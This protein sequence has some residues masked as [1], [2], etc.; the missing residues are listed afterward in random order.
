MAAECGGGKKSRVKMFGFGIPEQGFYAVE[1]PG[2]KPD[3]ENSLGLVT[4]LEG[5]ASVSK[6]DKE[7]KNLI[8]EEWDFKV[9]QLANGEYMA[10]FPDAISVDMFSKFSSVDLALFGLKARISKSK[11]EATATAILQSTW[12]KVYG[13]PSFAREEEIVK[14]L[15]SLA[16]EPIKVDVASLNKEGPVR[17][18]V[19]CRDPRKLRG[20]VEVFFNGV[21]YELRFVAEG[22][23][24]KNQGGNKGVPPDDKKDNRDNDRKDGSGEDSSRDRHNYKHSVRRE[25][26][27]EKGFETSQGDSMD[28]EMEELVRDDSPG[29]DEENEY[30][31]TETHPHEIGSGMGGSLPDETHLNMSPTDPL[32]SPLKVSQQVQ[33]TELAEVD[34]QTSIVT[35]Q[36]DSQSAAALEIPPGMI[37]VHSL[38]GDYL[39]EE[40]KWPSL[41]EPNEKEDVPN[42][43]ALVEGP[44]RGTTVSF[45]K[46]EEGQAW[47]SSAPKRKGKKIKQPVV[48]SRT[49]ARIPRTGDPIIE[50]AAK[51][52]QEKDDLLQGNKKHQPF[53]HP[54]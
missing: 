38:E 35:S 20:F 10:S 5:N 46:G 49:S 29:K 9:K 30:R 42:Q 7:L 8:D 33:G 47:Q 45:D 19:N 52:M 32:P 36:E 53:Y 12:I 15:T 24:G 14:D 2:V 31:P 50:K 41:I 25:K 43:D 1:I 21:G 18:K 28:E 16:A 11:L 23:H 17:V 48:A 39:V 44:S 26:S 3:A 54:Q 51:R 34:N 4:V 22:F 27:P 40:D 13:I 6:V 37:K